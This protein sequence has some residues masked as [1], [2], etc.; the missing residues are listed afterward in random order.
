VPMHQFWF[1]AKSLD[2]R[3]GAS[4]HWHHWKN[5][6]KQR[7]VLCCLSWQCTGF[8]QSVA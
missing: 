6:W 4:Y 7:H 8:W 5:S 1:Q 3:P 2:N